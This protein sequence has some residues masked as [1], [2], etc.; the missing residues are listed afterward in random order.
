M[1]SE[2]PSE[3]P[4]HCRVDLT[5]DEAYQWRNGLDQWW[6]VHAMQKVSVVRSMRV[7]LICTA[8]RSIPWEISRMIVPEIQ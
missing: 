3:R 1:L 6:R 8:A 5:N 2:V 7:K 4:A